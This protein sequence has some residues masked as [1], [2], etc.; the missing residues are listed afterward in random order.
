MRAAP[1][2]SDWPGC[3]VAITVDVTVVSCPNLIEETAQAEYSV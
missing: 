3:D 1:L 2:P